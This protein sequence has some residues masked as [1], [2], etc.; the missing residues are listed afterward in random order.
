MQRHEPEHH[1]VPHDPA[2]KEA[3]EAFIHQTQV[4]PDFQRRVM[5]RVQQRHARR[6]LWWWWERWWTW[7]THDWS[8]R[9]VSVATACG[10]VFFALTFALGT[11]TGT[12]LSLRETERAQE[13][14]TPVRL[15]LR[16]KIGIQVRSGERTA[17]AKRK[18]TV[19][20]GDFFRVYVVLEDEAYVYVV[21]NDGKT[22]KLLNTQGTNTKV[23]SGTLLALPT[24]EEFYEIDGASSEASI[25]V[26]CSQRERIELTDLFTTTNNPQIHW[27]LLEELLI[28]EGTGIPGRKRYPSNSGDPFIDSLP[29]FESDTSFLVRKYTFDVQR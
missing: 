10:M 24:P 13:P 25:T 29:S 16:A 23:K 17:L 21:H 28:K 6:G 1:E 9:G 4:P 18:E 20:V 2:L 3:F 12:H 22:L 8:P 26:V 19:H 14:Q 7:W 11:Y 15:Q 27:A 5:A